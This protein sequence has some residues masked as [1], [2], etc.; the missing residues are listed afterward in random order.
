[1]RNAFVCCLLLGVCG[2][3]SFPH[4]GPSA[5]TVA[6]GTARAGHEGYGLVDLDYRIAEIISA[7]RPTP[8]GGL[9][10]ATSDAP[11][12]RIAPG[13]IVSVAVFEP[14]T[15]D[16][17]STKASPNG[18][19]AP[20]ALQHIVVDAEGRV[21]FPYAGM[22]RIAGL[23]PSA[24]GNA[25]RVALRGKVFDP[26]VVLTLV[27]SPANSVS[28]IG[29]VR[30]SGRFPLSANNDRLM[31]ALASAGGPTKPPAD[32]VVTVVRGA[33]SV[34]A[35]LSVLMADS[36]QN[37]RLAPGDQIRLLYEPRKYSTFGAFGRDQQETIGDDGLTLAGAI[38]RAGG[39]DTNSA[40]ASSV[41]LFRFEQPQIAALLGVHL[42]ATVKGVPVVYRLNLRD[43]A[44]YL[45][46]NS[47]EVQA[48]DVIYVPRADVTET[49]KFL[50][51]VSAISQITYNV[52][53]T[54]VLN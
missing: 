30:N 39:L 42:P 49:K 23:T 25:I 46:S 34:S 5:T 16:M 47:F 43:P 33:K 14:G 32:V 10:S 40:N 35:P 27:S 36:N 9:A 13:D 28:V 12:D 44:G 29:E 38:S 17:F 15:D 4:D 1:M 8:L 41:L 31:D 11:N 52:R 48:N 24:A 7:T 50:D 45:I 22:V 18:A 51:F 54:S 2:C 6:H 19:T 26:Q 3:E 37:L 21:A 20:S 53:V